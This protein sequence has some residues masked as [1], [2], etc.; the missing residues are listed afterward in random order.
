[1]RGSV[2]GIAG[3]CFAA[4]LLLTACRER[5]PTQPSAPPP[6]SPPPPIGPT[7][8]LE[9]E[10]RKRREQLDSEWKR[11]DAVASV[12]HAR[13]T[14]ADAVRSA[15]DSAGRQ[16]GHGRRELTRQRSLLTLRTGQ[17]VTNQQAIKHLEAQNRRI[18]ELN[19]ALRKRHDEMRRRYE[20]GDYAGA[21]A[22]ERRIVRQRF[23][24][25]RPK[26][27]LRPAEQ[28]AERHKLETAV[29]NDRSPNA[30]HGATP[31]GTQ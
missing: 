10:E 28:A 20:S 23:P 3:L 22:L 27:M 16:R 17:R 2:L 31:R 9:A 30:I 19:E 26:T 13:P 25:A 11:F 8:P 1:M 4:A 6:P 15:H 24:S 7:D 29:W 21:L 12:G 14:D 18:S 5:A